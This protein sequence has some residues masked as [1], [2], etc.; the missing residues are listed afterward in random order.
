MNILATKY[1]FALCKKLGQ[2]ELSKFKFV[3]P[4][5]SV[6]ST[7]FEMQLKKDY[8]IKSIK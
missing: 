3:Y 6:M 2:I 7:Q 1:G 8:T 5:S 4:I